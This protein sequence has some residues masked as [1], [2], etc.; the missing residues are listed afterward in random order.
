MTKHKKTEARENLAI[1]TGEMSDLKY[2]DRTAI[3]L[4]EGGQTFD[5]KPGRSLNLYAKGEPGPVRNRLK[6][7]RFSG[8][9]NHPGGPIG[10]IKPS[11]FVL[12]EKYPQNFK[13]VYRAPNACGL[14][15]L[16]T[17]FSNG[18]VV[19]NTI[20]IIEAPLK[21]LKRS[22]Y[23][24]LIGMTKEHPDNHYGTAKMNSKLGKLAKRFFDK[25]KERLEVND[26]SLIWGGLF[27]VSN[28]KPWK[29][30]HKTHDSG[31]YADVRS[32]TMSE[33]QKKFFENEAKKM[34][35]FIELEDKGQNNEHWHLQLL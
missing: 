4:S 8:G 5:V 33:K 3:S 31:R 10:S 11:K 26:M 30:P 14:V 17:V 25:Y 35:F 27:D 19:E 23:I 32:K 13:Q 24:K 15:T 16:S 12:G 20:R 1:G 2:R 29:K 9:H 22:K 18:D 34:G 7:V 21:P 6:R 28:K